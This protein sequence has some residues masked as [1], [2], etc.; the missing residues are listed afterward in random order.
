MVR[1]PG[2]VELTCNAVLF[3]MD[4]TLVDSTRCRRTCLG[5]V[6]RKADFRLN[7]S[8]R[9]HMDVQRSPLWNTFCLRAIIPRNW[10]RWTI[11]RRHISKAFWPCRERQKSYMR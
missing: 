3:D 7:P 9:S 8:S 1:M 4:G 10:R 2:I 6:G 11:T 5:L